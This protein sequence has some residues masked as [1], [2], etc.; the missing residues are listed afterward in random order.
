MNGRSDVC[1]LLWA[2]STKECAK[3]LLQMLHW[4]GFTPAKSIIP[5][6]NFLIHIFAITGVYFH[7]TV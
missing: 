7:M 5:T 1:D 4:Y 2:D 6:N 3:D